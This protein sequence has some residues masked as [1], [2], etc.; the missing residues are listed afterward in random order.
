MQKGYFHGQLLICN[1]FSF[2]QANE[3]FMQFK[4][5]RLKGGN[6]ANMKIME[7]TLAEPAPNEVTVAVKSIGL[8]FADVFTIWGL[9]KA[10]PKDVFTP[11]LEYAGTIIKVGSEVQDLEIG[12]RVMGVTRFGAYTTH[13]NIDQRYVVPIPSSWSYQEGAAYLVQVLTAYYGLKELGNLKDEQTVLIHSG[14]GGVG[15]LANRIA[16][17]KNAFTI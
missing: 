2:N 6:M 13:L 16:K 7:D 1:A 12:T 4:S 9:Y 5:Y 14:G 10:A 15:L 11:G 17:K 8:N 3:S